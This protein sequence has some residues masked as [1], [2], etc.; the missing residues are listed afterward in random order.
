MPALSPGGLGSPVPH[1]PKAWHLGVPAGPQSSDSQAETRVR[2]LGGWL[3]TSHQLPG[4]R[5]RH[6]LMSSPG[7]GC[8][9]PPAPCD[10]SDSKP[11]VALQHPTSPMTPCTPRR[12]LAPCLKDS[13]SLPLRGSSDP[14][15]VKK[16]HREALRGFP[17]PERVPGSKSPPSSPTPHC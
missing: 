3:P 13:I 2:Q 5:Q 12:A 7:R 9:V 11:S 4:R 1:P 6:R 14:T 16:T 8:Q 17:R 10:L 15:S